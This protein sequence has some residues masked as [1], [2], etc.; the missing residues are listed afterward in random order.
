MSDMQVI[1]GVDVL[2]QGRGSETIVMIHGWPDT[3][4][5]WDAQVE[6]LHGRYRCVRFTLPGFDTTR[7]RQ[8][9]S[10]QQLVATITRIIVQVSPDQ[11][12][13][14]LVHDWGCVFG[15][16]FC[17]SRPDLVARVIAVDV[18][19][20]GTRNHVRALATQAKMMVTGYQLWLVL[21][22]RIGG[23]LGDWMTRS[24]ARALRARAD[25]QF[26][27]SCM[28]YPYD[29][30]WTGSAGGYPKARPFEPTCPMLFMYGRKKPFM[31]HSQEWA[32]KLLQTPGNQVLG[33]DTGHWIMTQ[34][35]QSFN[36]AVLSWLASTPIPTI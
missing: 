27:G 17:K 20:A 14:L 11:K 9:Y 29:I 15:Y 10:L 8:A 2:V 23:G 24:M 19:D 28:N 26:I 31:F 34:Q 32:G 5:L 1:D 6:A 12:V 21:A 13:T 30:Q 36:Q 25:P 3:Y 22:W 18:G 16:A 4:R 33:F 35:P 7:P